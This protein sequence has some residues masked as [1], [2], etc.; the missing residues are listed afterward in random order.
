MKIIFKTYNFLVLVATL[1][2][3]AS[4]LV[5]AFNL[6]FNIYDTYFMID[7]I[8]LIRWLAMFLFVF[9]LFYKLLKTFLASNTLS[10]FHI[11]L[12]ILFFFGAYYSA[13][14]FDKSLSLVE[15]TNA[16]STYYSQRFN[17]STAAMVLG[18]LLVQLLPIINLV[19]GLIKRKR[20]VS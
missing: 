8:P 20:S 19:I 4:L 13:Y 15:L 16:D 17:I 5:P 3:A 7:N 14:N 2:L 1:L 9:A 18:F 6:S 10:W 12:S 11:F